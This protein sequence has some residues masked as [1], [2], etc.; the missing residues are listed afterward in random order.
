MHVVW[1]LWHGCIKYS[2]GCDN[3][4][5]YRSDA[6][7]DRDSTV[8]RKTK[9]FDLPILKNRK[10]EYKLPPGT[11]VNTCF[12]SD[13]LLDLTDEWQEEA[14]DMISRRRDL[15]FLFI[16]KRIHRF[17]EH[18][19]A[20]WGDGYDHVTVGCTMEN[21]EMADRRL[22]IFL[23]MP[24][25]HRLVISEPLLSRIDYRGLLAPDKI[26]EVVVGGESGELARICQFDWVLDIRRQCVEAGVE[27][28]FKQTGARLLKDGKLY[29]IPRRL[30]HSQAKKAGI[31]VN[32]QDMNIS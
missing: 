1:N 32:R 30:Q 23:S 19:P 27:F 21:Q 2:P 5:V 16:T 26:E 10:G 3:C 20:D 6:R 8:P 25:K 12:T 7:Y 29:R 15:H 18:L 11:T 4:Y 28:T 14:W 17:L 24:I 13:F 22:P 31:N 9:A